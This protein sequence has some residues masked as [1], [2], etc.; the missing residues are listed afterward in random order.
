MAG[1]KWYNSTSRSDGDFEI[2]VEILIINALGC[3]CRRP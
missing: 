1:E 3:R 2:M